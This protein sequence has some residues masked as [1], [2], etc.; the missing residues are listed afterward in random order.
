LEGVR[1]VD[2]SRVLAGPLSTV[3]LADLGA[4]VIKIEPRQGDDCR[5]IGPFRAGSSALFT[6]VNP[7]ASAV[8]SW[9][10]SSLRRRPWRG[11]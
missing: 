4:E 9:I 6:I 2:F 3:L 11:S 10:S 7:A 1:I 5:A 8:W